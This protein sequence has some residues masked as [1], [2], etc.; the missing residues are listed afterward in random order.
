[1]KL[2]IWIANVGV[3]PRPANSMFTNPEAA[4]GFIN[5]VAFARSITDLVIQ[6][7]RALDGY[8]VDLRE[9]DGAAPLEEELAYKPIE[10]PLMEQ[11]RQLVV[12][13]VRFGTLFTYPHDD[14]FFPRSNLDR[15]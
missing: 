14:R 9:L 7:R 15:N 6:V 4:G 1:M 3:T 11:V 12:G 10:A 8:G 2:Q 13:E 5:A